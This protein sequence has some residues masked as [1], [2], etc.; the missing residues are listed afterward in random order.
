MGKDQ[1]TGSIIER[2][3]LIDPIAGTIKYRSRGGNWLDAGYLK[4]GSEADGGGYRI[5]SVP[6]S[7]RKYRQV[8]AHHLM[9]AWVYGEWPDHIDHINL[10]RDDNRI[11]NL[12]ISTSTQNKFNRGRLKNNKSGFKWC[13]QEGTKWVAQVE[14]PR[15]LCANGKREWALRAVFDTVEAAYE[16]ACAAAQELHGDFYNPGTVK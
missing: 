11:E 4:P 7:Y 5:I 14:R 9:W 12:R 1:I 13:H 8:R 6:V 3:F 2:H 15:S 16:A 10:N